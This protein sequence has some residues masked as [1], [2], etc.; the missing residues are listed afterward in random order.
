MTAIALLNSELDPH[1]IADTLLSVEGADPDVKKTIWLPA[2]GN[3]CSEWGEEEKL[4]HI[5]RL[6]RKSFFLPNQSGVLSF[7]GVCAPAAKFLDEL[8][9]AFRNVYQFDQ[10]AKVDSE[11]INR[12]LNNTERVQDFWLIG[13]LVDKDGKREPY[14]H[15]TVKKIET[16]HFGICYA[17]GSGAELIER[18]VNSADQRIT[19][20]VWRDATHISVTE[21]LAEHISC[22]MLYR[23]SDIRN[24][25][26]PGTPFSIGC[27]GFYEW[28]A[29]LPQG[30]K[31]M[32]SRLDIHVYFHEGKL[33]VSRMYFCEQIQNNTLRFVDSLLP[34][35]DYYLSIYTLGLDPVEIPLDL[36]IGDWTTIVPVESIGTLIGSF[37]NAGE[38]VDCSS[39]SLLSGS[40]SSEIAGKLFGEPM[41]VNRVRVI[42]TSNGRAI[43]RSIISQPHEPSSAQVKEVG[44]RVAVCLSQKVMAAV[45]ESVAHLIMKK[46]PE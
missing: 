4:W 25:V 36:L 10:S 2:L 6:G 22:E 3:T 19:A 20:G 24:G 21:D 26:E 37:L 9:K 44:G 16:E 14:T 32:R 8:S 34:S 38:S 42:V 13:V 27:G 30:V 33:V 18:L 43:T 45:V 12:A 35:Q 15:N 46:A 1:L 29:V 5:S 23:E 40:V 7:A 28:Y 11:F 17:A 41:N 39:K 31:P